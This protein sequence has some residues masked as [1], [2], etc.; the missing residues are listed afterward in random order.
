MAE[1]DTQEAETSVKLLK[2]VWNEG[3][4]AIFKLD[5][6]NLWWFG[7][8]VVAAAFLPI[9]VLKEGSVFSIHDQ[10]DETL[11]TYVLNAGYLGTR[12]E[13]FPEMLGGV[14]A[15]GMQPSAVLFIPLYRLLPTF[16]AFVL[17]AMIVCAAGY[18]GM[19]LCVREL[20]GSCIL[21]IMTAGIFCML[22]MQPV[23]GLSH[24]GVPLLIYAFLCLYRRKHV[25]ASL[26][27]TIFFGLTTHIILI[28]YVVLSFWG[29]AVL[30]MLVRRKHNTWFYTG[31]GLLTGVYV[32]VNYRL[33]YELIFGNGGYVSHREELVNYPLPFLQS[34]R[35]VFLE[36]AQ[37]IPSCHK[38]LI[39]P[40]IILLLL[41]GIRYGKLKQDLRITHRLA[42][43]IFLT[44]LLITVCYGIC[45][46]EPVTVW[47]NNAAGVFRYF[48][49][50]RYYWLYPTL[51][52]LDAA[53]LLSLLWRSQVKW[54]PPLCRLAVITILLLPALQEVKVN[55]MMYMNVN[56]INNGSSVTGYISWEAY[57]SEDLMQ[58][59][60][61]F[62]GRDMSSY[63]I[64]H[65]GISPA[66]ALMH[67]F[68]TIDG[69]SNNYP[70]SYK[71]DFRRIIEGE[72]AKNEAVRYYFDNWGSR[73]YLFTAQTG[74]FWM[75]EKGADFQ[76]EDL[77]LD[78]KQMR[79]MGCEYLFSGAEI[80]N[81][82]QLGLVSKGY[83][84][85]EGSFWGIWLYGI[86]G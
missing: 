56:Q 3:N 48:Q 23:Y 15:S 33:F 2:K 38:Y 52:Y 67:G 66:P 82:E 78:V 68:Y 30:I 17:Q 59:L 64:A 55:S 12:T 60:E 35:E 14:N 44:I 86:E 76:Y 80:L 28:G 58:E 84:E 36:S 77:D 1:E 57:Y 50:E 34:I 21:G 75:L 6:Q 31:F 61:D 83:F 46:S 65:L 62:I 47:K 27:L 13:I 53:L 4:K 9:A 19:Y 74:T 79:K 81:P 25:A 29:L 42:L 32:V 8:F 73:C 39:L 69:Y 63:R 71:H 72:L 70:L 10:L 40:I 43:G 45:K 49:A 7:L 24:L 5:S 20:T 26:L 41:F 54:F 37:H 11:L 18:F 85:T 16:S 22:P 51:W